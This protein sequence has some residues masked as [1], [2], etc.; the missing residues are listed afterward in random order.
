[1]GNT[2]TR[3]GLKLTSRAFRA[4]VLPSRH[5]GFPDVAHL[6]RQLLASDWVSADYSLHL[7]PCSIT[8]CLS[9]YPKTAEFDWSSQ[10]YWYWQ[11]SRLIKTC[12]SIKD[13]NL[14][15]FPWYSR[16]GIVL[17]ANRRCVGSSTCLTWHKRSCQSPWH[18]KVSQLPSHYRPHLLLWHN[19]VCLSFSHNR[20][21]QS[22]IHHGVP[23][24]Q[25]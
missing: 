21:C 9:G 20:V 11:H 16:V 22:L 3:V 13:N 17:W 7:L 1:M 24:T 14:D 5:I 15:P 6:S 19:R 10:L 2:V 8:W 18:N 25:T 23:L 12:L 4:S